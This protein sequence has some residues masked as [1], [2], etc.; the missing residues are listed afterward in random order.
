LKDI[1]VDQEDLALGSVPLFEMADALGRSLML[2][3]RGTKLSQH[4][5]QL[6][7]QPLELP[8][9]AQNNRGEGAH[10][11]AQTANVARQRWSARPI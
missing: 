5:V 6:R 8:V 3:D 9:V 11:L 10:V 2:R 7:I 1:A 4:V